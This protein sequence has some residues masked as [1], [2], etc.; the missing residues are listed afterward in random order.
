MFVVILG[1]VLNVTDL[2]L[3]LCYIA[4]VPTVIE[5]RIKTTFMVH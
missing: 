4:G 3:D 5:S 1:R 2:C